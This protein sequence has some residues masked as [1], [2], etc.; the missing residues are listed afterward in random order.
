M[1]NIKHNM[2]GACEKAKFILE[3]KKYQDKIQRKKITKMN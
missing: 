2:Y 3:N 1:S